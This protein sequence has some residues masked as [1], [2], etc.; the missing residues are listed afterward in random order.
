MYEK[1][2]NVVMCCQVGRDRAAMRRGQVAGGRDGGVHGAQEG[3]RPLQ[4]GRLRRAVEAA[5]QVLVHGRRQH[6]LQVTLRPYSLLLVQKILLG[7]K[8]KI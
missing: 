8:K 4:L 7:H 2:I 1:V 5:V 3:A 6:D